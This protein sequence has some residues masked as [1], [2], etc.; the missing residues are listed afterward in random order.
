[1]LFNAAVQE[2]ATTGVFVDP[3]TISTSASTSKSKAVGATSS[4]STGQNAVDANANNKTTSSSSNY[5]KNRAEDVQG[6][7]FASMYLVSGTISGAHSGT[8][9]ARRVQSSKSSAAR[10]SQ[11]TL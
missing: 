6:D 3:S 1:M 7:M 2:A 9:N 8:S 4:A 10:G 11:T 5:N